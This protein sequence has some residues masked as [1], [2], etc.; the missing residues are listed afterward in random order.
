MYVN[1]LDEV[2]SPACGMPVFEPEGYWRWLSYQT[3]PDI[4]LYMMS[5]GSVA[6]TW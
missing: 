6:R 1:E 3:S 2:I 4:F 5:Y